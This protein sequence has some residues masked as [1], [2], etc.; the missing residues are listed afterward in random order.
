[1]KFQHGTDGRRVLILR[2]HE[3]LHVLQRERELPGW[4]LERDMFERQIHVLK[5]S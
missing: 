5:A 2:L 1:M 4:S 3:V